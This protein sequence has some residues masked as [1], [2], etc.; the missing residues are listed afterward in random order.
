[1]QTGP[2]VV[3]LTLRHTNGQLKMSGCRFVRALAVPTSSQLRMGATGALRVIQVSSHPSLARSFCSSSNKAAAVDSGDTTNDEDFFRPSALG[4]GD[5]EVDVRS[6]TQQGRQVDFLDQRQTMGRGQ[7]WSDE[8]LSEQESFTL[9]DMGIKDMGKPKLDTS[10][11]R[12]IYDYPHTILP[13]LQDP[14][15]DLPNRASGELPQC[16]LQPPFFSLLRVS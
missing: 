12:D 6:F 3:S 2:S 7:F 5:E 4:L 9:E 16:G 10:L 13:R 11:F 14:K 8:D 1:M 15:H